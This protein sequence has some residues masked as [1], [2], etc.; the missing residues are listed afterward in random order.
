[1]LISFKMKFVKSRRP[2]INIID[3][4]KEYG[5]EF[6]KHG[7]HFPSPIRLICRG[8]NAGGKTT[9][10][11]SMIL[12]EN[13]L[14]FSSIYLF[15][16]SLDQPKYRYLNRLFADMKDIP[17]HQFTNDSEIPP[18]EKVPYFSL[19]IFDDTPNFKAAAIQPFFAFGRH[20]FIDVVYITQSFGSIQKKFIKDGANLLCLFKQDYNSLQNIHRAY[21]SADMTFKKFLELCRECFKQPYGFL[22]INLDPSKNTERYSKGFDNAVVL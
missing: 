22:L 5:V 13:G 4:D 19:V 15:S 3:F 7:E 8:S 14:R 21:A 20:R 11:L 1:M 12:S 18:L 6:S 17:L 9:T 2:K 10:V 16:K